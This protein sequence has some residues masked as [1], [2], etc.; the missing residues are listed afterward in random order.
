MQQV[1]AGQI[2]FP[3]TTPSTGV[4]GMPADSVTGD[5][6]DHV[7]AYVIHIGPRAAPAK[8]RLPSETGGRQTGERIF[9]ANCRSC[10]TL[11]EH[12]HDGRDD[13][14]QSRPVEATRGARP[15]I[16]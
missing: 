4:T 16:A 13:R 2:K 7:A 12:G 10:H 1:V 6:V 14:P 5:D 9:T 8:P 15:S 11:E 3:V